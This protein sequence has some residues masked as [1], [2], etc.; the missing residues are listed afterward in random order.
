MS[1]RDETGAEAS[2][3]HDGRDRAADGGGRTL[4]GGDVAGAPA[5]SDDITRLVHD[6]ANLLDGSM[7]TMTL[8]TRSLSTASA[9]SA[10]LSLAMNRLRTVFGAMEQMSE[11]LGMAMRA[12]AVPIGSPLAALGRTKALTLGEAIDHV[13]AVL[14]PEARE[15]RASICVSVSPEAA[16][17]AAGQMYSVILNGVKNAVE[18]VARRRANA[19]RDDG[20]DI[21]RANTF[22]GEIEIRASRL[23]DGP[24]RIDIIDNGEGLAWDEAGAMCG[25]GGVPRASTKGPG[26]GFGLRVS[27]QIVE[28]SGGAMRL[29]RRDDA[30]GTFVAGE[31]AAAPGAVLRIAYMPPEDVSQRMLGGGAR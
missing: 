26:R 10:E 15:V 22:E 16:S 21:E 17:A 1:D 23:G 18:A 13:A 29:C 28:Q 11:L 7:R 8:A 12:G 19:G 14:A 4:I 6:L 2:S 30:P 20:P 27:A 5:R 3:H 9:E 25:E 24:V 31:N